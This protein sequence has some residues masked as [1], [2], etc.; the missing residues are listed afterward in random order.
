MGRRARPPDSPPVPIPDVEGRE[1][2]FGPSGEV[3]FRRTEEGSDFAYRVSTDGSGLRKAIEEPILVFGAVSPDGRWIVAWAP[4]PGAEGAGQ[5]A[6]SLNGERTVPLSNSIQW[7]W[8][9]SGDAFSISAGPV[10]P[11]R[12]YIIPLRRGQALPPVPAGGF[13]SEQEIAQLPGARRTDAQTAVPGPSPEVYAFY[14]GTTQRN[15][16]RV[17]VR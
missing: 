10:P 4:L 17:P 13:G 8:S 9:P 11:G 3:F 7:T 2:R 6:F 1:P 5:Q 12:S 15:L 16:Y 14:R